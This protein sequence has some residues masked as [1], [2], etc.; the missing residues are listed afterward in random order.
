M[1]RYI[2]TITPVGGGASAHTTVRVDT[3]TGQTR[4][5][6]LIV[7]ARTGAGLAP[8]DLPPVDLDLLVR[9]LTAPAPTPAVTPADEPAAPTS[10]LPAVE[11]AAAARQRR[12][13]STTP[14]KRAK[15]NTAKKATTAAAAKGSTS[16]GGRAYRRMPDPELVMDA[17]RQTGSIAALAAHFDVPRHTVTGW[18]RRLRTQGHAI[19]R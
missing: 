16:G 6:E 3:S 11:P 4:I 18:A 2:I 8:A 14:G 13:A 1:S 19:G 10:R 17:Y 7:E 15:A 5:T 12:T 9:A